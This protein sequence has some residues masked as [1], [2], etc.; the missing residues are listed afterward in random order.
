VLGDP[1]RAAVHAQESLAHTTVGRPGWA[2]ATLVLAGSEAHR[3]RPD[4]AAELALTVLDVIPPQ[5]LRETARQRLAILDSI[6][7]AF[8]QPGPAA[9][10]LHE[11]LGILPPL[12][13]PPQ[14]EPEPTGIPDALIHSRRRSCGG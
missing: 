7:G 3:D 10:D 11:R 14:H 5:A 1:A 12:T 9:H 2:A 4:Q 13:T 8:D 6:L